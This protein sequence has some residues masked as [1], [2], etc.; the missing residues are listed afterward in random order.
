MKIITLFMITTILYYAESQENAQRTVASGLLECY[1]NTFIVTKDNL[2]PQNIHSFIDILRKVEDSPGMTMDLLQLTVALL[3]RFR[4]DGIVENTASKPIPG[5]IPYAADSLPSAKGTKIL[6]L[7]PGSAVNFP[8]NSIDLIERCTLHSM[9]STSIE[10]KKRGDESSTCRTSSQ[11][12]RIRNTEDGKQSDH[13]KSDVEMLTPDELEEMGHT[14]ND[15]KSN[16]NPNSFYPPLPPNHPATAQIKQQQPL[17]KCP[18]ENGVIYTSWGTVTGGSLLAGLA[19]GLQFQTARLTDLVPKNEER[20]DI[21]SNVTIDNKWFATLAGDLAEITLVQGPEK[22]NLELGL[23]GHWNS[24]ILPKYYFLD[25]NDNTEFTAAEI[26]GGLDGLILA[27]NI[28][29]WYKDVPT[30]RLSQV[31]DMYYSDRGVLNSGIKACDRRGLL[32]AVAPT[33][34]VH[35]QTY[36]ASLLLEQSLSKV[37]ISKPAL[38][39]LATKAVEKLF[40]FIPSSLHDEKICDNKNK[41][42]KFNHLTTDLTIFLDTNWPF[43]SIQSILTV[44]LENADI[45]RFSSNFT[46]LSAHDG[47]VIINSS[48]SI[49]DFYNLNQTTYSTY[50]RG[51]DLPKIFDLLITRKTKQLNN[52]WE[53]RIGGSRSDIV[54]IITSTTISDTDKIYCQERLKTIRENIPDVYLFFMITGSKEKWSDLAV[55][56][57]NDIVITSNNNVRVNE[58]PIF[59][60]L[61]KMKQ[62]PRRLINSQCGANYTASGTSEPYSNYLEPSGINFYRLHPNYFYKVDPEVLPT[63]KIQTSNRIPITVCTSRNNFNINSTGLNCTTS[64]M[65]H[66]IQVTCAEASYIHECAPLYLSIAANSSVSPLSQCP[67]PERCRYPDM[68]KYTI[69]YENLVCVNAASTRLFSLISIIFTVIFINHAS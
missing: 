52:E 49:L 17:S 10:F 51:L 58:A 1:N 61:N 25:D 12:R 11:Y 47:N 41:L 7:I 60:L 18:L 4:Q 56:P 22:E 57:N 31:L 19:A 33:E 59:Y 46:L 65:T 42:S 36:A 23:N 68:L 64:D 5:V 30:L 9:V 62:I 44:L 34:T 24:S 2:L 35:A 38:D 45:N 16:F 69:S 40:S 28:R 8:N 29:N 43:S 53:N 26:R 63:L 54:L 39:G 50:T 67:D 15:S 14:N 13:I 66:T 20:I 3:H 55:D 21:Y 37:S 48:H 27:S 32:T 6:Q